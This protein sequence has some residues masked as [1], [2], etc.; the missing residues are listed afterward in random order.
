MK[1][2]QGV[3]GKFDP[4]TYRF[5]LKQGNLNEADF[6]AGLRSDVAR[7]LLQGAVAGGFSAPAPLTDTLYAYAGEKRAFSLLKLDAS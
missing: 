5:A 3:G 6:E 2:F 4:E 7:S 1:A